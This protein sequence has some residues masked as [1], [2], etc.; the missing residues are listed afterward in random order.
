MYSRVLD[1]PT[2]ADVVAWAPKLRSDPEV[3]ARQVLNYIVHATRFGAQIVREEFLD[4][5]THWSAIVGHIAA[6]L[7]DRTPHEI[8]RA[9]GDLGLASIRTRDGYRA[10]WN[11]KQLEILC[12]A[13]GVKN[14]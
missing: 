6:E 3:V 13:L 10:F 11:H 12:A 4:G 1:T 8:G 5:K 2:F 7:P 9:C 14:D